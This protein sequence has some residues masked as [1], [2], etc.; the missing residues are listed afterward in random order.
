MSCASDRIRCGTAHRP[1]LVASVGSLPSWPGAPCDRF[2]RSPCRISHYHLPRHKTLSS[3][4]AGLCEQS[5]IRGRCSPTAW[6]RV[7]CF[8]LR[9][10]SDRSPVFVEDD[11]DGREICVLHNHSLDLPHAPPT[12]EA[13]DA[14]GF[15]QP[16][17]ATTALDVELLAPVAR[18]SPAL[19]TAE[20][21][22]E[23][24]LY[25]V[26]ELVAGRAARASSARPYA[27][28][29]RRGGRARIR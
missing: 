26:C 24:N 1:P 29:K 28:I 6:A 16:R 12:R 11:R 8:R 7:G 13:S 17:W 2:I 25:A 3:V 20:Q 14:P 19:P 15:L 4:R 10:R 18:L 21:L 9:E 22:L 5:H 23:A 27:S